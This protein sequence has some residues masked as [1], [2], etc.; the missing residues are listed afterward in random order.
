MIK[1]DNPLI[2][3][4]FP[5]DLTDVLCLYA[6]EKLQIDPVDF[7][8]HYE[9]KGWTDRDGLPIRDWKA[10]ARSWSTRGVPPI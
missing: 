2:S 3:D 4:K 5:P 9:K 7:Y 8:Y 10:L 6:T 1:K